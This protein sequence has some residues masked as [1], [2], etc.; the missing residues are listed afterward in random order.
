MATLLLTALG[1]AIGGPIGGAVGALIGQQADAMIFG[2]GTRQGPRL[3]ELTVSTS[4]YGQ[5][6]ARHFGRMRVPGSVIWSTDLIESKRKQKGRKGQ[7][8]TVTY[9]YSASFAIALSSTPIARLGRIWA[10]GNLLRGAQ[11][12]LK[13]A[14]QLRFYQGY[15]DDPVDPLIA[16]DK[17]S[18]APGFRDCAYVV[19]EELDLGDFGN[20][21]PALSFEI[22]AAGGD[23]SVS[24]GAMVPG[25]LAQATAKI[26]HA[27]G[28]SDEGGPLAAT[29]A[30]IDEVIPLVCT[31]GKDFLQIAPRVGG[32]TG[33]LTLPPQLSMQD[34]A[35]EEGRH[36]QRAG[37]PAREPA[38]VRYYDEGR[39]YQPG[40][41]R[42]L[43]T[44]RY[45]R[46]MMVDLPATMTAS[47]AR[48]LANDRANRARWQHETIMW[49]TSELDPRL[50]PGVTVRVPDT[51]GLWFVRGWEWFDRG[52][53]FT[54]ERVPPNLIAQQPSDPGAANPPADQALQPTILVAFEAPSDSGAN[55]ATPLLFAAASAQTGAWRGAALYRLQANSLVPLG[56]S[57]SVRATIGTLVEPLGPSTAQLFEP[58]ASFVVELVA[59]D[60]DFT[61]T[62]IEGLATGAN[63]VM[64]GSEAIQF[65][66]AIPLGNRRWRLAGLLRGRAGT[67]PEA[68][69]GHA[70]QTSIVLLDD[71]LIALDPAEVPALDSTRIAAIG[72]GDPEAV[73]ASLASAGLSRRPLTPVHPLVNVA[74]DGVWEMCWT[75]RARGQWRWDD[76]VD[77]PLVEEREAY[78]V[79]YGPVSAPFAAWSTE[80]PRLILSASQRAALIASW[81]AADLWVRQ[82]GTFGQSPPLFIATIS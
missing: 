15:G 6:I 34:R 56:T 23:D 74:P 66:R 69:T 80:V 31:S 62:D 72:T 7:P 50:Q 25:S 33:T 79:G 64:V 39:D 41:Q 40:V 47:G 38:A 9:S 5:P 2:G 52:I 37:L 27:R 70:E 4:S 45:G 44:R 55:P 75:R 28:F 58:E 13:V 42:A 26:D 63:R 17:G 24:L 8:S 54:L 81:G 35:A 43:G 68:A 46:E 18:N 61:D 51:P 36:K 53:E 65:A 73:I 49:R 10:D 60:L 16:A 1:T 21:I 12:D 76:G 20:R 48:Q 3:R 22:F 78:L 57:G 29:L 30:A 14:G 32:Q 19:F 71:S 77:V 11:D 82:V 67:E 59:E